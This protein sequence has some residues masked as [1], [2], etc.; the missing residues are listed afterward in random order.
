MKTRI[1]KI[2]AVLLTAIFLFTFFP[3][4]ASDVNAA[5]GDQELREFVTRLYKV[6]LKRDPDQ[7]GLD[8]WVG[9]LKDKKQTGVAVATGFIFS[10]ELQ[11]KSYSNEEYVNVMY[12][13]FFG[14]EADTDGFNY[15]VKSMNEGLSR[16]D[17][18]VGFANSNEFF[19]LC[20]SFD[21]VPGTF[22]PGYDQSKVIYTNFFVERLYNVV[23]DRK[24][25]KD[26]MNYWTN[27]LLSGR[28]SGTSAASGF[29]FSSEYEN[30]NKFYSEY[31]DDL[32]NALMGRQADDD[33]RNF[34]LS[35]MNKGSSKEHTFNG[36]ASSTE[37]T[38]IC[39]D[40][41][42][43][44]GNPISEA[45]NTTNTLRPDSDK[46]GSNG[47]NTPSGSTT[48][49]PVTTAPTGSGV[50]IVN[51]DVKIKNANLTIMSGCSGQIEFNDK[52]GNTVKVD[53]S[54]FKSDNEAVAVAC[55][56]GTV[57]GLSEGTATVT[58]TYAGNTSCVYVTVKK[59]VNSVT[60]FEGALTPQDFGAVGDGVNDDTQAFRKMFAES[61]GQSYTI[62]SSGWRHCQTIYIPSGNYKITGAVFD[63]NIKPTNGKPLQYCMFEI[64]GAG[65][66]STTINFSG[67]V[68]FDSK[69]DG[70]QT[71]FAFTTIRDINFRGNNSN[72]F[73]TMTTAG[74]DGQQRMQFF[75]CEFGSFHTILN[76]VRGSKLVMNS[77]I[78]FAYCKIANCGSKD[79]RCQ[80]FIL[81]N[82]QAVNW[83]FDNTD[84]ES[85]TGD[86]FYFTTGT[87]V[88][89]NNGSIIP[90]TG[91]CVFNF[92]IK[93]QN[94]LGSGN[95]PQVLAI[96]A[97]FEIHPGKTLLKTNSNSKNLPKVVFQYC[98]VNASAYIKSETDRSVSKE[99]M[100]I[101]GGC[102][103]V[104]DTCY[105]CSYG[106]FIVDCTS[107]TNYV[108]PKV[109]FINCPDLNI[110]GMVSESQVTTNSQS[111][112]LKNILH[113][114][115]DNKYDFYLTG[116]GDRYYHT[117]SDIQQCRQQ[118]DINADNKDDYNT[119]YITNGKTLKAKPYGY[120]EY[121]EI[122]V[123]SNDTWKGYP[124][125][126]TLYDGSTK[127]S[128]TVKIDFSK[129]NTYQIQITGNH[130]YVNELGIKFTHSYSKNPKVNMNIVIVKK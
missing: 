2:T 112:E 19:D 123:P 59:Y 53:G 8:Y 5:D 10:P 24:C 70:D 103:V 16:Q 1:L 42:I 7:S 27:E 92:D 110:D 44:K 3:V 34:W 84:I 67:S 81:T 76:C 41:G 63:K 117:T 50:T 51:T 109:T 97:R 26:G 62:G 6:C 68:L 60:S 38:T 32:Y 114:I 122:T 35:D 108:R 115:V 87:G 100:I 79:N 111:L 124:V 22:I 86:A 116:T 72:T 12:D 69:T 78:T 55:E 85:F 30:K 20:S 113:I 46:S 64:Y 28:I 23:L 36:F 49:A 45:K 58:V 88:T 120:V 25:D 80:L 90:G 29:F 101:K 11:D 75:S 102:D 119:T 106:R 43:V 14:R 91:G 15:W 18:F 17:I 121:V 56:D 21:V 99:W 37:F 65:R 61:V 118:V 13:A 98:N 129:S 71:L 39:S 74:D 127:I 105:K 77:E 66:E 31:I 130:N 9:E 48:T 126:V 47:S 52:N 104:F 89:I 107:F 128:D 40:Y 54:T 82:P 4:T 95:A 73:M 125:N 83:R 96:G 33:G 93:D 94:N 57:I